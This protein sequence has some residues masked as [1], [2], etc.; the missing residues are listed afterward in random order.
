MASAPIVYDRLSELKAF[1]DT[2]AGAKGLVDAGI[3]AIPRIFRHPPDPYTP[4]DHHADSII[5]TI[6][7]TGAARRAELVAEVKKAAE[8]VGFFQVINHGVPATVMSEMLDGLRA[9]HEEPA[10][11]KRPYYTRDMGSRVRYHSNFDLFQSPAATWRDTLYLDMAPIA[12]APEEIPPACRE[13]VFE[14]T[15]HVQ[16]LGGSL[17]ELMSEALGLHRRYL[18]HDAGC[19]DGISIVGHYYPPCPEPDLT[20][21]TTRHSD[22]SFLTVLLQDGVVGGL[23][24]LVGG[25]W[26]PVPP[27]AGA[28]VVNVGDFLQLMSNDRF[29]SVEHRVVAVGAAGPPRVSVACFFRPRGVA[30]STRVYGPI[31]MDAAAGPRS[32]PRYR[33]ITAEEF[34]NH[35]MDKGLVGKSALDHFRI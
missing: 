10:E 7:F 28:F 25:R 27:V 12:P 21:G 18:S 9:F 17:L 1:D 23:Q 4:P 32:P 2:K 11:A 30:A 13:V 16:M 33:S 3:T 24:V 19:L 35:Y 5:P 29:K 15:N 22:P 26:V 34:I 20:L 8:T 31:V 14:Y 6:D